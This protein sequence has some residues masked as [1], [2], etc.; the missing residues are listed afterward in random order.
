[1]LRKR[2]ED[3]YKVGKYEAQV[4]TLPS[5]YTGLNPE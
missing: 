3:D 1:V 4:E 5:P 2:E